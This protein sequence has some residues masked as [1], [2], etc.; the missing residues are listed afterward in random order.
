[1]W[2]DS[3]LLKHTSASVNL[4]T[5]FSPLELTN[6]FPSIHHYIL[7]TIITINIIMITLVIDNAFIDVVIAISV[8]FI[9]F[10]IYIFFTTSIVSFTADIATLFSPL[11]LA[12]LYYLYIHYHI[13]IIIITIIMIRVTIATVN[14]LI[15]VVIAIPINLLRIIKTAD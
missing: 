8:N 12:M 9:T 11:E 14:T 15:D 13:V 6:V 7:I 3:L 5:L 4:A 1:M 10:Y 2:S